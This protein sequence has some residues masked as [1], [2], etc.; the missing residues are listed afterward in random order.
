MR[1]PDEVKRDFV[2]QWLRKAEADLGAADLLARHDP[3]LTDV[4]CFHAQQ[5]A[6]K[7]LKAVLVH[8]QVEF[9]KIHDIAQ[10]LDLVAAVDPPGAASMRDAGKLSAYA[11]QV[12][13]PTATPEASVEDAAAAIAVAR[14]VRETVLRL[15]GIAA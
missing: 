4:V 9:R 6:E 12:R 2:R 3:Y 11:V 8:H 7:Y 13:Y 15:L 10:L 14:E 1:P 5:A